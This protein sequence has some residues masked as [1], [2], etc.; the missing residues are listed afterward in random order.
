MFNNDDP[1][2]RANLIAVLS[3][4]GIGA[5]QLN[6]GGG[7]KHVLIPLVDTTATPPLISAKSLEL[8][9]RL[10]A[11]AIVWT[12][13]A[14]LYISTNSLNTT[15]DVGLMGNDGITGAQVASAEWQHIDTLEECVSVIQKLWDARDHWLQVFLAGDLLKY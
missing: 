10:I 7:T 3:S 12:Y 4:I 1:T 6:S 5:W 15:C 14:S 2:H 11:S 9:K 8:K 13:D